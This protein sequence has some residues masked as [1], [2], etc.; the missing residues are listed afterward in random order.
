MHVND[1]TIARTIRDYY[2]SNVGKEIPD[3]KFQHMFIQARA[4]LSLV[5]PMPG[6]TSLDAVKI[7]TK[8]LE[9]TIIKES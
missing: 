2:L 5:E 9:D 7:A 6:F 8:A 3:D 1:I 4:I